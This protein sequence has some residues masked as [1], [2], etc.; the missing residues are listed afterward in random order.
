VNNNGVDNSVLGGSPDRLLSG[1]YPIQILRL[2]I[3]SFIQTTMFTLIRCIHVISKNA[4]IINK[5]FDLHFVKN[6]MN[7][8]SIGLPS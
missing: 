2:H 4:N 3:L 1:A 5:Q 7:W 6:I 8:Y